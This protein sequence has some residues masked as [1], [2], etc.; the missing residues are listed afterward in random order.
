MRC[1]MLQAHSED[2][3][4]HSQT[5]FVVFSPSADP[6]GQDEPVAGT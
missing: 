2:T 4:V 1:C 3:P 6:A 5:V